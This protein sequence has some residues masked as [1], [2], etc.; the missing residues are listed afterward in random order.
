MAD[1]PDNPHFDEGL[2]QFLVELMANN[3]REWFNANKQRYEQKVREPARAIVRAMAPRLAE[4]APSLVADD[5]KVGGSLMRIYRDTRFSKDKTPYK[6]NVGIQF[7]HRAGKDVHAPGLYLHIDLDEVFLGVG[8]WM[9]PSAPLKQIRERI[10]ER[11]D[12]WTAIIEDPAFGDGGFYQH[13]GALKRAPRGFPKD[14]PLIEEIK[15]KSFIA[16]TKLPP[17]LIESPTLCDTVAEKLQ[18][19]RPY[20]AFICAAMGL[21]F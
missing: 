11:P 6:T 20:P 15:R 2:W 7:R 16:L 1:A 8:V 3:E 5:R 21:E 4:I 13:D 17:D 19:I 14:H 9:P 18:Q 12:D 10:A